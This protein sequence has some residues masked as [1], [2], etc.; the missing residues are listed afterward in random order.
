MNK[1]YL[2]IITILACVC[3]TAGQE[4]K[5]T[6]QAP[7]ADAPQDG[8]RVALAPGT[9]IS[10]ELQKTLDVGNA[11]VGDQI[12]LK[13][14]QA[15]K[16]NGEVVVPKGSTLIG[17]VTEVQR[18]TKENAQ[19]RL[20]MVFERIQGKRLSIPLSATLVSITNVASRAS[21]N[22]SLMTDVAGSSQTTAST[23]RTS[24]GGGAGL[25]GGVTNTVGGLVNTTTQTVGTVTN[26]AGQTLN[27]TTGTIGRGLSGVQISTSA[28][29][30]AHSST[31][32]SSANKN[33]RVE[34]GATFHLQAA[35]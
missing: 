29:G 16:Q 14:T 25:L 23:S 26:T 22:D 12:S 19:S 2:G 3:M 4:R 24:G 1:V 31:T 7:L 6:K 30:S 15:I 21:A 5:S 13:T 35:N 10:A 18:R 9:N 8:R 32:L 11:R 28:S 17:R 33:L 27:T 20:G 34:K